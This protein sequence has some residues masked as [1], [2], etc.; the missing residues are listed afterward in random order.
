M[1]KAPHARDEHIKVGDKMSPS[2]PI[3]TEAWLVPT[4]ELPELTSVTYQLGDKIWAVHHKPTGL[5][6]HIRINTDGGDILLTSADNQDWWVAHS[7]E[8]ARAQ[9]SALGDEFQPAFFV[10]TEVA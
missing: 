5:L 4:P 6:L 10:C 8:Q 9:A 2:C 3:A 1:K 7:E